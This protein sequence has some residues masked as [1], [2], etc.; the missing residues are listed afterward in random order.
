VLALCAFVPL[1]RSAG[2]DWRAAARPLLVALPLAHA[3]GRIGCQLAGC[4]FGTHSSL[5]FAVTYSHPVALAM[6]A[7]AG[8][9]LHPV[10][11]YEAMLELGN[12]ALLLWAFRSRWDARSM[13]ALWLAL[14]GCERFALEFLRGD[15]R[16]AWWGVTTS[17]WLCMLMLVAAAVHFTRAPA[18]RGTAARHGRSV[19]GRAAPARR[20]PSR[21][22]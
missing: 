6:G 19:T 22:G 2:L 8:I 17:Q 5:P 11:L 20:S 7:P 4:C 21:G 3:V 12:A 14:Y 15:D 13:L 1:V 18:W 16:G 9:A 10:P